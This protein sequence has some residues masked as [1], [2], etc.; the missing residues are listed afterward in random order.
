MVASKRHF[1]FYFFSLGR[2]MLLLVLCSDSVPPR[3]LSAL[4]SELSIDFC[5]GVFVELSFSVLTSPE[6]MHWNHSFCGISIRLLKSHSIP[7]ST[8]PAF[9]HSNRNT[10][11]NSSTDTEFIYRNSSKYRIIFPGI[12]RKTTFWQRLG[13]DGWNAGEGK[14]REKNYKNFLYKQV[15]LYIHNTFFGFESFRNRKNLKEQRD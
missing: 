1:Y 12:K 4:Y 5:D 3:L 11:T 6:Y 15:F 9:L 7:A 14:I 10:P 13:L 2:M 8:V